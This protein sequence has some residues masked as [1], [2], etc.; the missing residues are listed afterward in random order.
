MEFGLV[1]H[2]IQDGDDVRL[3][4]HSRHHDFIED[5]VDLVAVEDQVQL[6]HTFSKHLSR[7]S[8]KTWIRSNIPRSDFE[9]VDRKHEI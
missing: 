8:T 1:V 6:T 2:T 7:A 4:D 3:E 5:V 9:F